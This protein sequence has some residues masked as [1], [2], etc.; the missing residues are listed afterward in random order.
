MSNNQPQ[1]QQQEEETDSLGPKFS[2]SELS[3]VH[4]HDN[5]TAADA[6]TLN[7]DH[8]EEMMDDTDDS[9]YSDLYMTQQ[10]ERS[11][12][13]QQQHKRTTATK[14]HRSNNDNNKPPPPSVNNGA[15]PPVTNYYG[16]AHHERN[17][18]PVPAGYVP[19]KYSPHYDPSM[20]DWEGATIAE[21]TMADIS[22][23]TPPPEDFYGPYTPPVAMIAPVTG[24]T[25][26]EELEESN[27]E[28]ENW[29]NPSHSGSGSTEGLNEKER[30]LLMGLMILVGALVVVVAV[31]V[32]LS[33]KSVNKAQD[34]KNSFLGTDQNAALDAPSVAPS[35]YFE[36]TTASPT[37]MGQ[38]K[39]PPSLAPVTSSPTKKP[40]LAPVTPSP[41]LADTDEPTVS[42]KLSWQEGMSSTE[43]E[44]LDSHNT[45]RKD[46]HESAGETYIPLVWSSE[47]ADHALTWAETLS[48]EYDCSVS[49]DPDVQ[50]DEG[51]NVS[52]YY[53]GSGTPESPETMLGYW[54]EDNAG[55]DYPD[56]QKLTQVIWRATEY[57]GC[58]SSVYDHGDRFCR[59][60]VCNYIRPGNCNMGSYDDWTVPM[61]ADSSPCGLEC[62]AGEGCFWEAW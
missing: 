48:Q 16:D 57:V 36:G 27:E 4:E 47:L 7:L 56:N 25:P 8:L 23:V 29:K 37:L 54:V 2:I 12:A 26:W 43:L 49:T 17:N 58:A 19:N 10:N 38:T 40:T 46:Y 14:R 50:G 21:H 32:P 39:S 11:R 15:P 24:G 59:V 44:W 9:P 20:P 5:W 52:G 6:K 41:T 22:T 55:N 45:R 62:P 60:H 30:K 61:L 3:S 31:V 42:S 35:D 13:M 28:R 51:Q 1:Q 53:G 18:A 34:E 33:L